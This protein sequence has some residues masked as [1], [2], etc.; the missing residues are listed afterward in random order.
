GA[1]V[2]SWS[3]FDHRRRAVGDDLAHRIADLGA[4]VAH[5]QDGVRAH[6]GRVLDQPIERMAARL[7]E[8]LRVFVDFAADDRSQP[9]NDVAAEPA[10]ADDDTETL[11]KGLDSA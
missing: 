1:K 6:R 7:L 5:H 10:A 2:R 3:G 8:Q 9:S 4:V 11:A